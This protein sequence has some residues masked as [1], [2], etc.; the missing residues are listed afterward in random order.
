MAKAGVLTLPVSDPVRTAYVIVRDG[1]GW[2]LV[3][4]PVTD[5]YIAEHGEKLRSEDSL[6]MCLGI[7]RDKLGT[8]A[9]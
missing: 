2:G 7:A 8:V 1:T 9:L 5:A 4:V 3:A 6:A